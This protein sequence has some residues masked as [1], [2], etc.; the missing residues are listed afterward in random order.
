MSHKW[1]LRYHPSFSTL[2]EF[3]ETK[4]FQRLLPEATPET[5]VAPAK[6]TR[7][8][9]CSGQVYYNLLQA[10]IDHNIKDVALIRIEQL[11]PFPFDLVAQQMALYRNAEVYWCQEEPLNMGAWN[12]VFLHLVNASGDRKL[13]PKYAGR[14]VSASAAVASS[15]VHKRQQERFLSEALNYP[16]PPP[17]PAT[18][19]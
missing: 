9:F 10:R 2:S 17:G 18:G 1:L 3:A 19:H 8:V 12:F 13:I 5:L 6:I 16:L 15:A 4:K 14:P 11:Y 7:V